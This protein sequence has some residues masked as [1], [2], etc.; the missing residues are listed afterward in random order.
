MKIYP[1]KEKPNIDFYRV[2]DYSEKEGPFPEG[3]HKIAIIYEGER[4]PISIMGF[5]TVGN[6]DKPFFISRLEPS[7]LERA[8]KFI[9]EHVWNEEQ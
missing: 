9:E 5:Q 8:V 1:Y 7:K 2:E 3:T 4:E 6:E